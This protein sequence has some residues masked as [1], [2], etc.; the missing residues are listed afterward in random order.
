METGYLMHFQR[1]I[2]KL[3]EK[4]ISFIHS[5]CGGKRS[6]GFALG[7]EME[8]LFY[9][10]KVVIKSPPFRNA[11]HNNPISSHW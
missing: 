6:E 2:S 9:L 8:I 3:Y 5:A 11:T 10:E 7:I 4:N 1:A